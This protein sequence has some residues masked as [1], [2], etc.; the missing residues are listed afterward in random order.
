[1]QEQIQQA[2]RRLPSVEEL[3]ESDAGRELLGVHS[4]EQV[5]EA[6]RE[7]LAVER[8]RLLAPL[9][10][11]D[12]EAGADASAT[13]LGSADAARAAEALAAPRPLLAAAGELLAGWSRP[14]LRRV[15][16][17]T[18]VVVHTNLGRSLLAEPAVA[19][20]VEVARHYSTL[21][22]RL[23][24]GERGSRHDHVEALLCRLTGA[25]AAMVVNNNAAAVLLMLTALA[26]GREVVVSR[27]QL[28]EIGGS[29]RIPDIMRLS[30]ATLVEVGTTNKTRIADYEGAITVATALLL[31]V[32]TS[33]FRVV[34]FSEEVPV[35]ELAALGRRAGLL[36]ADDQGSGAL[37]DLP[38]FADEPSV[39]SSLGV[40]ADVV[41]F[42]GDK[43][44]GGPQAGILLGRQDVIERLKRHPLTRA[45]RMDKLTLAALEGTLL[46]YQDPERARSLIPTLRYLSRDE[47]E[48]AALAAALAEQVRAVCPDQVDVGIERTMAKAGGG[49]LP[50]A[51]LPSHAVT[52]HFAPPPLGGRPAPGID[53]LAAALRRAPV[54]LVGRVAQDR[55]FLDVVTLEEDLLPEVAAAVAFALGEV[56]SR[57]AEGRA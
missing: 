37:L 20:V 28:V 8:E 16:N 44:L 50:L 25:E 53:E 40:G 7:V 46:L 6:I 56:G 41:S 22:Y 30:G 45:L 21:E 42:S 15:V 43:L 9:R 24:E 23:E 49:S 2:L 55:L 4:R 3:L 32:H 48:T 35:A 5:V 36:V 34:G 26:A 19:Q 29:F 52:L 18:G 13:R 33:N 47:G 11:G 57:E 14:H 17:A 38:A 1:V 27:G 10:G 39:V 31:R 51:E 54:P 12:A